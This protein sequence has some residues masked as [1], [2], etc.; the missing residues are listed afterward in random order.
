MDLEAREVC[1][2]DEGRKIVDDD[3]ANVG[4][5][6]FA[7]GYGNSLDPRWSERWGVFLV[8]RFAENTIR[9]AFEGN[10]TILKMRE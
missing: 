10:W 6:C 7:A 2:P 9:K 1:R 5:G 4:A 3:V 8:E